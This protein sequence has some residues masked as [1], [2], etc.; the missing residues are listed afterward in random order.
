MGKITKNIHIL[1]YVE[2]K[3]LKAKSLVFKGVKKKII[4]ITKLFTK[5]Y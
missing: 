1:F 4:N 5:S 3:K 2:K